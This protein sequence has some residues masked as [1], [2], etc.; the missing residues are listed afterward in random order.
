M[1]PLVSFGNSAEAFPSVDLGKGGPDGKLPFELPS[2][3]D[4]VRH[5]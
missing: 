1:A 5:G 4:V 3:V 2:S